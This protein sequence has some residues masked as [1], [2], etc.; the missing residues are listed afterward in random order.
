MFCLCIVGDSGSAI[1]VKNGSNQYYV[2]GLVSSGFATSGDR[3]D[4]KNCVGEYIQVA[5]DMKSL[6]NWIEGVVPPVP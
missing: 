3:N 5:T 4:T 6:Y 1:M 2:V